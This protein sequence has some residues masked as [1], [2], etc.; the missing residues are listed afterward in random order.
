MISHI[1]ASS[2]PRRIAL[3][4]MLNLGFT[5][6]PSTADEPL[7]KDEKPEEYAMNLSFMKASEVANRTSDALIIGADTI[8]VIDGKILGKPASH[9]EAFEMLSTLSGR[10]HEVITGVTFLKTDFSHTITEKK[11]FFVRTRVTFSRLDSTEINRY[12]ETGS[13]FDKAGGYGI[14]DDTGAL[15]V[16]RIDG[17][18]Y[19]VVGFPLNRFYQE[20]KHFY[21]ELFTKQPL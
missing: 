16:E 15:F 6:I 13:P 10:T 7:P 11:T 9:E 18:Y 4:G 5:S 17:D 12:I 1:L 21:P 19:N 8:V 20:M 14:Q 2:S 3:L